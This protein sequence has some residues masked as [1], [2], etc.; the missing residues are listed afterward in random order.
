MPISRDR[1]YI[2]IY[3]LFSGKLTKA[4]IKAGYAALKEIEALIKKKDFSFKL[5]EASNAFYT[6]IPHDFGWGSY[7]CNIQLQGFYAWKQIEAIK[8]GFWCVWIIL[9]VDL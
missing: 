3:P 5:T 8:K 9:C 2:G 6:R 1:R 4:Q 7:D